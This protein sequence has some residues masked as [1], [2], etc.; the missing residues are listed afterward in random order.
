MS[1][2]HT[3]IRRGKP[4]SLTTEHLDTVRA[5]IRIWQQPVPGKPGPRRT[6]DLADIVDLMLATGARI[7]HFLAL[8]WE[9]EPPRL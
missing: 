5:A 6:G 8:R 1:P 9:D 7:G 3:G 4:G 2:A